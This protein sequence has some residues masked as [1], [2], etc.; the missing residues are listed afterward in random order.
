MTEWLS[1]IFRVEVVEMTLASPGLIA[2]MRQ[3]WCQQESVRCCSTQ[4]ILHPVVSRRASAAGND[5]FKRAV[6]LRL[7]YHG[8]AEQQVELGV[9]AISGDLVITLQQP[10]ASCSV[11]A[12]LER[13]SRT[14]VRWR[15][16]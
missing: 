11:L 4:S 13:S 7:Q 3:L 12:W 8:G 10:T 5:L 1:A 14:A 2:K 6:L 15:A 16:A 9:L